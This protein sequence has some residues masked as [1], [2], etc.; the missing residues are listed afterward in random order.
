LIDCIISVITFNASSIVIYNIVNFLCF[1]ILVFIKYLR[2]FFFQ[3]NVK[4]LYLIWCFFILL[5]YFQTYCTRSD[6]SIILFF[7]LFFWR[8]CIII[9]IILNHLI[10]R[11]LN[12]LELIRWHL[13]IIIII[14]RN[15][16]LFFRRRFNYFSD[17]RSLFG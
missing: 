15:I 8:F 9:L 5:D 14:R 11:N 7:F 3:D 16:N 13:W 17:F 12:G 1:E 2:A 10:C 6:F 4:F